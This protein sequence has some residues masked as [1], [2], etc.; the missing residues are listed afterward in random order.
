LASVVGHGGF[1]NSDLQT[2]TNPNDVAISNGII[3]NEFRDSG[4]IPE[5][6]S[7]QSVTTGNG[8]DDVSGLSL[9]DDWLQGR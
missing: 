8:V 2:L 3:G 5:G 4:A 1:G 6:D 7:N 9:A